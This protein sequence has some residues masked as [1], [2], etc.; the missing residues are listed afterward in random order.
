MGKKKVPDLY[1]APFPLYSVKVDPDTGLV[2]I[3]G[4]GGA[5]KTGI[6]NAVVSTEDGCCTVAV[7]LLCHCPDKAH[8]CDLIT[9]TRMITD[10][11]LRRFTCTHEFFCSLVLFFLYFLTLWKQ[12][13][14]NS[15]LSVFGESIL[16]HDAH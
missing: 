6:K 16:I 5:S 9:Y 2:I 3:A 13:N 7:V 11:M 8:L 14:K 1:R 12:T 15:V 4:G 10:S